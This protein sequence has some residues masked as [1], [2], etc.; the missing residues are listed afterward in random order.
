MQKKNIDTTPPKKAKKAIEKLH[1]LVE[2]ME[3]EYG[4][5]T[6]F[7][8]DYIIKELASPIEDVLHDLSI[9]K[10]IDH[11][12]LATKLRTIW[13]KEQEEKIE[14][15]VEERLEQ[16]V[17]KRIEDIVELIKEEDDK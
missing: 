17:E 4:R 7:F 6:K 9:E 13:V 12:K 2:L 1:Q 8:R 5:N 14:E 10:N 3:Y 15:M 11:I 16:E